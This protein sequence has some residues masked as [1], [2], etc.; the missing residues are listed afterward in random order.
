MRDVRIPAYYKLYKACEGAEVGSGGY[1]GLIS[2]FKIVPFYMRASL[3]GRYKWKTKLMLI[4][5]GLRTKFK[6][7]WSVLTTKSLELT[8]RSFFSIDSWLAACWYA[9]SVIY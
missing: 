9:L 6:D 2:L 5:G 8:Y 1:Q 4:K 3:G 7:E